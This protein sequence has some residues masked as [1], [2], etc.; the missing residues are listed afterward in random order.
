M[1]QSDD[2]EQ[3]GA[4]RRIAVDLRKVSGSEYATPPVRRS[5][6]EPAFWLHRSPSGARAPFENSAERND[7]TVHATSG[8]ILQE[9]GLPAPEITLTPTAEGRTLGRVQKQQQ[10]LDAILHRVV[11]TLPPAGQLAS[12]FRAG[13]AVSRSSTGSGLGGSLRQ[14][15]L[16]QPYFVPGAGVLRR[17][18]VESGAAPQ[19]PETQRSLTVPVPSS[20]GSVRE[21]LAEQPP[22]LSALLPRI[23]MPPSVRGAG[24]AVSRL[25]TGSGSGGSL[26]QT[27]LL[28]PY[29]LPGAGI[30]QRVAV[31]VGNSPSRL[32]TQRSLS[33]SAASSQGS[34]QEPLREPPPFLSAI[35]P[36]IAIP[37]VAHR[38]VLARSR[39]S[40]G[41][42]PGGSLRQTDLLQLYSLSGA[43]ILKRV[44]VES[45][46]APQELRTQRSLSGS[47]ASSQGS[48]Q[49]PLSENHPR[50]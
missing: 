6:A 44:A 13:L 27:D 37:P 26:R 15:D 43:G 42:G 12:G 19:Q 38:S 5:L 10:F 4:L 36:R 11:P 3:K 49:E 1:R 46:T 50:F 40:T 9:P 47:A 31:G 7:G 20:Q 48:V 32:R 39:S 18:A 14:T 21:P 45:G 22:F 2:I 33:G 8:S 35:L 41:S 16:L 28:R 24:L 29:S 17:V 30:L 25:S 34:V 23:A